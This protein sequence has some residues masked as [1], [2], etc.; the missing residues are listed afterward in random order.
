MKITSKHRNNGSSSIR[1]R[2][3]PQALQVV[4]KGKAERQPFAQPLNP[5]WNALFIKKMK[6]NASGVDYTKIKRHNVNDSLLNNV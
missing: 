4:G 1:S 3:P 6:H 2:P 5:R